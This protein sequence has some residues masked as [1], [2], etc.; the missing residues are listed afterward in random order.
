MMK[1]TTLFFATLLVPMTAHAQ[2]CIVDDSLWLQ[3]RTGIIIRDNPSTAPCIAAML[4]GDKVKIIYADND[5][6][7]VHALELR[8]WLLALSLPATSIILDKT[9]TTESIRLENYHD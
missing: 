3:P 1:Y 4:T 6:A 5:D 2:T 8:Q 7:S 9:N